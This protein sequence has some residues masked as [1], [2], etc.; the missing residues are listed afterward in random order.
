MNCWEIL[1]LQPSAEERDIK[2]RYAQLVKNCH[3]EDDPDAWQKLHDAYEQALSYNDDGQ[4]QEEDEEQPVNMPNVVVRSRSMMAF[5]APISLPGHPLPEMAVKT[6][7]EFT[8]QTVL[9]MLFEENEAIPEHA[10]MQLANALS[11]LEKNDLTSRMRFEEALLVNLH[12]VFRPLLTLAAAQTFRW[13]LIA[14]SRQPA[15]Q[16]EI[17]ESCLLYSRIDEQISPYFANALSSLEEVENSKKLATIYHSL[18]E[19]EESRKWFDIALL[20]KIAEYVL[21]ENYL[22][23]LIERLE[24]SIRKEKMIRKW[25]LT[26]RFNALATKHKSSYEKLRNAIKLK[27]DVYYPSYVFQACLYA[28]EQGHPLAWYYVG[29]KYYEGD[30]VVQDFKLAFDW[31]TRAARHNVIDAQYAL[32][33][34]YLDGRG[35]EKNITLAKEHFLT[36]AQSGKSNGQY[37]LACIYR[38]ADRPLQDYDEALHWYLY[39]A[40]QGHELAQYELGKMYLQGIGVARDEVQAHRWFLQSAEQDHLDAQYRTARLYYESESIPQDEEKALYWFTKAAKNGS[41]DAMYELG[42]YYLANNDNPENNAEAIQWIT[43]AGQRGRIEAILLLAELYLQGTKE[44]AKDENHALYW[45]EKAARLGSTEAQQRVAA[46][47][48]QGTGTKIDNKQ[49]W[50]WLTIAGNNN[51]WIEK[52]ELRCLM[53]E[54]DIQDAEHTAAHCKRLLRI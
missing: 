53:S 30:E 25:V 26:E 31:F 39:A 44:T 50:M 16:T 20:K 23:L 19:N 11:F 2:R 13:H 24:Y 48:A 49:A 47:Y 27:G 41:G 46:M 4:W 51:P 52:E 22:A 12:R 43:G 6:E 18:K 45:Y 15:I 17:N 3:P 36:V 8:W 14:G 32:G 40:T 34:M 29:K 37:E 1:G 7:V 5:R 54:Q 9:D 10:P 42:K 28:A 38:F 33:V 35:V 21:S